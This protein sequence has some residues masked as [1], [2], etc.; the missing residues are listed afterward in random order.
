[1]GR[2]NS[3]I[4]K[5]FTILHIRLDKNGDIAI[6]ELDRL[7]KKNPDE[8]SDE[9]FIDLTS[10][11]LDKI[12]YFG[13]FYT[14]IDTET[15]VYKKYKTDKKHFTIK[16]VFENLLDFETDNRPF[17][18]WDNEIDCHHTFFEGFHRVDNGF[19]YYEPGWGS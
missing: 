9:F 4:N 5:I 19:N 2:F 3:K 11:E 12:G 17:T 13:S 1:M 10:S 6:I 16:E 8:S 14:L 18:N 15:G 7:H